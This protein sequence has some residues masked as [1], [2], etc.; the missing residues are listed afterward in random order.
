MKAGSP[1][2]KPLQYSELLESPGAAQHRA[3]LREVQAQ[4]EALGFKLYHDQKFWSSGFRQKK[5]KAL[6][7]GF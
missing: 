2:K 1:I 6:A 7:S 4:S 5:P 3:D